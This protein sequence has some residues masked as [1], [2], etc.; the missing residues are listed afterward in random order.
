MNS[1][2]TQASIGTDVIQELS[3]AEIEAIAGGIQG[4]QR[5]DGSSFSWTG[6]NGQVF[7]DVVF[8]G[9][10]FFE[11]ADGAREYYSDIFHVAQY[12][13][14]QL[15]AYFWDNYNLYQLTNRR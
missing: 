13:I 1:V 15:N 4:Y 5:T 3:P 6:P 7:D 10:H 12:P 2:S 14:S 11:Y 9:T 8:V